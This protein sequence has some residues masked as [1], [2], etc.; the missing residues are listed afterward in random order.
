MNTILILIYILSGI[1]GCLLI[2]KIGRIIGY[3]SGYYDGWS[4]GS[5]NIPNKFDVAED[6]RNNPIYN[7]ID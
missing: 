1:I 4:E 5:K 3:K 7:R 6:R 2:G